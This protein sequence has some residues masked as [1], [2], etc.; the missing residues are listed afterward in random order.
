M[1]TDGNSYTHTHTHTH[2]YTH[3]PTHTHTEFLPRVNNNQKF[4]I[5]GNASVMPII[6]KIN[7]TN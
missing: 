4:K 6:L 3:T 2:I 5:A 7:T 1:R